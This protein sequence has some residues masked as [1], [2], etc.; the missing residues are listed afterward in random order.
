MFNTTHTLLLLLWFVCCCAVQPGIAQSPISPY[1]FKSITVNEKLS[2][3]DVTCIVQDQTGYI[4][5]G[6]NN[7]L[8]RFNGYDLE[9]FKYDLE[10]RHSLPGNRIKALEMGPFGN[11]WIS[12]ENKGVFRFH[13]KQMHFHRIDIPYPSINV[14]GIRKGPDGNM[15]L[16]QNELG[17][18]RILLDKDGRIRKI[19]PFTPA[20]I[21][22]RKNER[23]IQCFFSNERHLLVVSRETEMWSFDP[24]QER[25]RKQLTSSQF[26][27]LAEERIETLTADDS[28]FWF[29]SNRGRLLSFKKVSGDWQLEQFQ[30][31]D[32]FPDDYDHEYAIRAIHFDQSQNLWLGT[33]AGLYL[34]ATGDK[35]HKLVQY[36]HTQ[37]PGSN[38]SSNLVNCL[39][40][41]RFGILWVGTDVG[42]LDYTNLRKKAFS[43]IPLPASEPLSENNVVGAIYKDK[44]NR[45]WIGTR[46]G[47]YIYNLEDQAYETNDNNQIDFLNLYTVFLHEDREGVIWIG[48]NQSGLYYAE[49]D[50]SGSIRITP[51]S[52]ERGERPKEMNNTMR[53]TEDQ[54]GRLWV[55]TFLRGVFVID[56]DRRQ[57]KQL[58][59][60]ALQPNSLSS[61]KLT[62]VYC[63]PQDGSIW[64]STRDAGLNHITWTGSDNWQIR[65]YRYDQAH[66]E[67]ISSNHCWQILRSSS[68]VLWVAT[69][70]GGINRVHQLDNGAI[71]FKRYTIKNG[72]T[73]NDIECFEEDE[74]GQLWL[75]GVGLTK[76]YPGSG[77]CE[78]YYYRDGLQSNSFK[79]GASYK[80]REGWLYFGGIDGVNYFRPETIRAD[81]ILPT[82]QLTGLHINDQNI[83]INASL[84]G[85]V[86]LQ[87]HLSETPAISLKANE[88]NCAIDFVALQFNESENI[89]YAYQLEGLNNRWIATRYPNLSARYYNIPPGDYTFKLKASNGDG[90]WSDEITTLAIH[91]ARPWYL[92]H[93]ACLVYALLMFFVL[94][95]F[96]QNTIRR[97][98]LK[99][100]LILAEKD[101]ELNLTKLRFFTQISHEL[102]NPLTLIKAPLDEL[103]VRSDLK[104]HTQDK[105][106]VIQ[107]NVSR[108][109]G[110]VNQLLEFRKMETGH[111]QL[112]AASGNFVKFAKEIF[113]IFSQS[114]S[115]KGIKYL[116]DCPTEDL[117][118]CFDRGKMEIV[119]MNLLHNAYKYTPNG[120]TI[121][122]RLSY[123]GS[124]Q[125][126]GH[127][128]GQK[129][130]DHYLQVEVVD[131]GPGLAETEI[132]K[133]F[134]PYYQVVNDV[135]NSNP[136][137]AG[138]GIGLSLV[139]SITNLHIGNVNVSSQS[140]KGAN[141]QIRLPFGGAQIYADEHVNESYQNSDYLGHYQ[142]REYERAAIPDINY[143]SQI[144]RLQSQ[145]SVL[146]V[147]DNSDLRQ[148]L[149]TSLEPHFQVMAAA[150]GEEAYQ[151]IIKKAPDLIISDVMMP[152]MN[153][154]QL[155]NK[156]KSHEL[157]AHIPIILLTA[158]TATVYQNEGLETGAEDY[159]T[160]P[161]SMNHLRAKM[162]TILQN[163]EYLQNFYRKQLFLEPV[164][165]SQLSRDEQLVLR[166]IQVV[167]NNLRQ[168]QFNLPELARLL[169]HSKS[170][171]YRK[172]KMVTGKTA[173][174][175]MRDVR[176]RRAAQLLVDGNL[177]V[178]EV[179][180]QVGF[181]DLKYF[182]K[183]FFKLYDINPSEFARHTQL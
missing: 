149:Q 109:L 90:V 117:Q 58:Q 168:E 129:L 22:G 162:V 38:I 65:H 126:V 108:L 53:M 122:V 29:G 78:Q 6:T 112:Q 182:R 24:H 51:W 139:K 31:S 99:N 68:G 39:Y 111:M 84:N 18:I 104:R 120:G 167:E 106:G 159:I 116:F 158:R 172:I 91:I 144:E 175:F 150:N 35:R 93:W 21:T 3:S 133:I 110:L 142:Q 97:T 176:L 27:P 130:V 138:T 173:V 20:M 76:L 125:Q 166:A 62:D 154:I 13:P 136:S 145:Y 52:D 94:L 181:N 25:F 115:D 132:E 183:C 41:D 128:H 141:F 127:Y 85:R 82:L 80:D 10:A 105:L 17:L 66:E 152:V 8:N 36:K 11:I 134:T 96:R 71:E 37:G 79:I 30:L 146:I 87:K 59:Y 157:L 19:R 67:S 101:R 32:F 98:R 171:L 143:L 7:G 95:L 2:H 170:T 77:T 48:T 4:W 164:K 148:Y 121:E 83:G 137:M 75:G 26:S 9:I 165:E 107:R 163:R 34:V 86:L 12:I 74:A 140:G 160:K 151:R 119:L 123:R 156:L 33:N 1:R 64:V 174:E 56:A 147:E 55:S 155:C 45:I 153:G 169:G 92:T 102:R 28:H 178:K 61:N 89:Q 42:G 179:A 15:W 43:H 49:V 113:L 81:S 70:G 63:D 73:D 50:H 5:I 40:E 100:E 118:L 103:L 54:K 177:T 60:D 44:F 47:L 16:H 69:L 23:P 114:A 72:L 57:I 135:V 161:F 124:E 88:N 180:Y 46:S 14:N 131:D